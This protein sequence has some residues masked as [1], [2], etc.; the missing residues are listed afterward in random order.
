[1]PG[2]TD[3]QA[4]ATVADLRARW[5]ELEDKERAAVLLEDAAV[6]IRAALDEAGIDVEDK[7]AALLK[8]I[9]CSMVRRA[10]F[11]DVE[12]GG[13]QQTAGTYNGSFNFTNPTGALYLTGDEKRL[14]GIGKQRISSI[15]P[16]TGIRRIVCDVT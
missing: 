9:S 3:P 10:M 5:P 4:F 11:S 8:I 7:C 16:L 2:D 15:S 6:R 12:I 13:M 14:L 1:M